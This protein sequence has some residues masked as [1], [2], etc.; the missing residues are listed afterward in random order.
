MVHANVNEPRNLSSDG[1]T[2]SPKGV[3]DMIPQRELWE[4]KAVTRCGSGNLRPWVPRF[5]SVSSVPRKLVHRA[6][7]VSLL[8]LCFGFARQ[9]SDPR[10]EEPGAHKPVS[11]LPV[12]PEASDCARFGLTIVGQCGSLTALFQGDMMRRKAQSNEDVE[13]SKRTWWNLRT[14][15][16]RKARQRVFYLG[17]P[18]KWDKKTRF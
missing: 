1:Y 6:P 17:N 18:Q 8:P 5:V 15:F 13:N 2:Q 14:P 3:K 4:R 9:A 7:R 12:H 11:R 16:E 10:A